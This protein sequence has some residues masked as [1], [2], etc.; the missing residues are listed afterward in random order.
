MATEEVNL[1]SRYF[2]AA[3]LGQYFMK[4]KGP[5]TVFAPTNDALQ[6]LSKE[7]FTS[8]SNPKKRVE[9]ET[10]L[11]NHVV[12]G[13]LGSKDLVQQIRDNGGSLQLTTLAGDNL[14]ASMSGTSIVITNKDGIKATVVMSDI[15]A[16]N[17]IVH[18]L[19]NVLV[20]KE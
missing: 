1:T 8:L 10:L 19:D 15:N 2:V 6:D 14:T 20:K 11:K 16:S 13:S 4:E 3:G 18:T 12:E 7:Q 9:L 17:G 5:F